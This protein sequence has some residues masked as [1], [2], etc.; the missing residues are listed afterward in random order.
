[1][2]AALP[3]YW[4]RTVR[5]I[6]PPSKNMQFSNNNITGNHGNIDEESTRNFTNCY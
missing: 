4:S 5:E 6:A 3:C 2:W 1:L